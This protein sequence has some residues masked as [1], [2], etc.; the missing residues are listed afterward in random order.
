[1]PYT[2]H[3]N[4]P[5]LPTGA[6]DW[7]AL[8]N[9][10]VNKLEAG[11]TLKLVAHESLA[12]GKPFYVDGA[13]KARL[14]T[15]AARTDGI[16][17]SA[18]TAADAQGYGQVDGI[19][20]DDSW[21]W[22]PGEAIYASAAGVLTQTPPENGV[23]VA[24]ALTATSLLIAPSLAEAAGGPVAV[25][26]GNPMTIDCS[27]GDVFDITMTGDATINFI[28]GVDGKNVVLRI[29]QDEIGGRVA[30]WGAMTRFSTDVTAPVLSIGPENLDYVA[31][32]Y[33]AADSTYD[34]MAA[35][36]G[37]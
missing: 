25:G 4:L 32:R 12:K 26:F 17:Q 2:T 31:F 28:N 36:K 16:W 15:S 27:L 23:P 7:M 30:T 13:G 9:D 20:S 14:A 35:N 18:A 33:N 6:V 21:A 5:L 8:I 10:L 11:R 29:R 22:T 37:F 3:W 34:C 24:V 1:M 19:M